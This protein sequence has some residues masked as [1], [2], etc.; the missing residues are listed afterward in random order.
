[1]ATSLPDATTMIDVPPGRNATAA[2]RVLVV[3][4]DADQRE[5]ICETLRYAFRGAAG[6]TV[7]AGVGSARECLALNLREFDILLL[8]FHLPDMTAL[9]LL[10][11]VLAASDVP[12]VFVTGEN[13]SDTAAEAI[14]LGAQ[15]YVVKLG[16]YLFALPVVVEKNI[17]QHRLRRENERLAAQLHASLEEI[18]VKNLQLEETNRQLV[19]LARTDHLTGL[20]NRRAFSEVLTRSYQEAQRYDFDLSCAMCDLDGY[21]TLN[22]TLGHQVGDQVLMTA[23]KVIN[24]NL[25]ASDTAARY[26]GDEFVLLLPHTSQ[27]LAL[28]VAE[29]ILRELTVETCQLLGTGPGVT[30]SVGV[31]SLKTDG[32]PSADA[33]VALADKALYVAKGRGKNLIV[34]HSEIGA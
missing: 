19:T 26:G 23:A 30:M 31:A 32:P 15:D 13:C 21:K 1:M 7:V 5:L 4:D 17:R 20:S 9:E 16:D 22:D 33:L 6:T 11:K 2:P 10:R 14:R 18:H 24:S 34:A 8:D 29:R 28:T 27:G 12:V 25:R 3:E